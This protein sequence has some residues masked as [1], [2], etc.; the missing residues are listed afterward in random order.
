MTI[1][2]VVS[3]AA[4]VGLTACG[5]GGDGGIGGGFGSLDQ[6]YDTL[7]NDLPANSSVGTNIVDF[8]GVMFVATDLDPSGGTSDSGYLGSADM[9]MNFTSG[10]FTGSATGFYLVSI[11]TVTGEPNGF[12]TTV[13]PDGSVSS[14]DVE[15]NDSGIAG[16]GFTP[17]FGGSING[18]VLG[19]EGVGTFRGTAGEFVSIIQADG[20]DGF[21]VNGNPADVTIF[22]N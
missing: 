7:F 2:F 14:I 1:R 18:D 20:V 21:T 19:G 12:L 9:S 13:N 8:S 4:L 6:K 10:M 11:D 3:V 22:G 16:A 5:G 15:F 17:A